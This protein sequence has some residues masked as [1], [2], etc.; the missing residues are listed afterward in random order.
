MAKKDHQKH[1][2]Q[3]Q[4][5]QEKQ[6]AKVGASADGST[7]S[8]AHLQRL[9]T[10]LDE[11][12]ARIHALEAQLGDKAFEAGV[13]GGMS[14]GLAKQTQDLLD[15]NQQLKQ[16]IQAL[17][18]AAANSAMNAEVWSSPRA[19]ELVEMM[20]PDQRLLVLGDLLADLA[21]FAG[22]AGVKESAQDVLKRRV[23]EASK[24]R[25]ELDALKESY[26]NLINREASKDREISALKAAMVTQRSPRAGA[27]SVLDKLAATLQR[28]GWKIGVGQ[29]AAGHV[30][31][32]V[33]SVLSEV[34]G[35]RGLL[36]KQPMTA[37][38]VRDDSTPSLAERYALGVMRWDGK[39]LH[40]EMLEGPARP[41]AD[42]V[43]PMRHAV[44][45]QLVPRTFR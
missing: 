41:W 42:L 22:E 13:H 35:F 37:V 3:K 23:F 44:D 34:Q 27:E 20:A 12:H 21:L 40:F 38:V 1:Q 2:E 33:T 24:L 4:P 9:S 11:A 18:T 28:L 25:L 7:G 32:A 5:E 14:A 8:E 36:G 16:R 19:R 10:E 6:D 15:E 43:R 45:T 39:Q 26:T 30:Y 29:E 17:E 31:D